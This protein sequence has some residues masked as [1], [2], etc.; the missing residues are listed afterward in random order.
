MYVSQS[1]RFGGSL[2]SLRFSWRIVKTGHF[3]VFHR[4][5]DTHIFAVLKT[6]FPQIAQSG[7]NGN[8]KELLVALRASFGVL[9]TTLPGGPHRRVQE[10]TTGGFDWRG[11][12]HRWN[13]IRSATR[14]GLQ[15]FVFRRQLLGRHQLILVHGASGPRGSKLYL[16]AS[17]AV[18]SPCRAARSP[19][20]T[21]RVGLNRPSP[22]LTAGV[23]LGRSQASACFQGPL[24]DRECDKQGF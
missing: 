4:A 2:C 20:R 15:T 10:T 3:T 23:A 13:N 7:G 17:H 14:A 19:L 16:V 8:S 21:V 18:K 9:A 6:K 24:K 12:I 22:R 11:M 5:C 1:Q